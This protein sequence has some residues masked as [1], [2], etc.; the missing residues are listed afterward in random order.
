MKNIIL[1]SATM[2]EV[3]E[4]LESNGYDMKD[5]NKE[6]AEEN[7]YFY[8]YMEGYQDADCFDIKKVGENYTLSND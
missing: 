7:G 6:E 2:E 1:E 4:K 8:A 3:I 5:F